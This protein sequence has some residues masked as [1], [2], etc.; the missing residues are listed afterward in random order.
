MVPGV[1]QFDFSRAELTLPS[2]LADLKRRLEE[3]RILF[4]VGSSALVPPAPEFI[5][6]IGALFES[7]IEAGNESG[8]D[9]SLELIG[10][11]DS[12]GSNETNRVLGQ[13]R[14]RRVQ[15]TLL[16]A[17]V[18]E[19]VLTATGIGTSDPIDSADPQTSA[20][21]NRSVSLAVMVTFGFSGGGNER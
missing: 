12:T 17:G 16:A 19:A 20:A 8:Y 6:E 1:A 5:T 18:P 9:V 13:T 11:T 7:L 14:A 10:R 2:D 3:R 21:L 15:E 4:N